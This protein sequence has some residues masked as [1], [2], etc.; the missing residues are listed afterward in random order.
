MRINRLTTYTYVLSLFHRRFMATHCGD[1]ANNHSWR[2][3][4]G[5]L[6]AWLLSE[7]PFYVRLLIKAI[8]INSYFY[9]T[10]QINSGIIL[11]II[12]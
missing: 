12:Y 2:I 3:A 5:W 8:N 9:Y 7:E 1:L 11:S 10:P 6:A 4:T